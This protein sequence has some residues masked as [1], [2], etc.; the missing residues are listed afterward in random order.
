MLTVVTEQLS[1]VYGAVT[2]QNIPMT[3]NYGALG[4]TMTGEVSWLYQWH[5]QSSKKMLMHTVCSQQTTVSW[6]AME[7]HTFVSA[8]LR[9][10]VQILYTQ[11]MHFTFYICQCIHV[12]VKASAY[13][14]TLGGGLEPL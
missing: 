14:E 9:R 12:N 4:G 2:L 1:L 13:L 3:H 6:D 11:C 10:N 7:L 5:K 8:I